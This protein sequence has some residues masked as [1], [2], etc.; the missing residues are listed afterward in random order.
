MSESSGS[1]HYMPDNSNITDHLVNKRYDYLKPL[2]DALPE[3][4]GVYQYYDITGEIIYV[5]K[6]KNLKKRVASYFT[7]NRYDSNK[8]K[9]LV[10]KIADIHHIVV[11]NESDAFLLENNLIK[12]FQPRYNVQL[13]DDKTFPWICVKNEHFPRVFSTRNLK[14]DGSAYY[15]PYTSGLMVKTIIDLIRQLFPLRTC[16]LNLADESIRQGKFKV[17]LEYHI[18][19]CLA[20]CTGQQTLEEYSD[21]INN[22]HKILKGN[23]KQVSSYLQEIMSKYSR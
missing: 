3:Q 22:V 2:I 15:G 4:A 5:G 17:C 23:I 12:K 18:G 19:N 9:L 6:A 13:K 21:S 11:E 8:I 16:T 7:R 20:P 14:N 1:L 10:R